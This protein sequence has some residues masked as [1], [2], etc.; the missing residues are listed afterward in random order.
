LELV[1]GHLRRACDALDA[2]SGG[3]TAED[4]LDRIFARF[5]LGK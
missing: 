1:A 3:T 5:C 4:V 2:V